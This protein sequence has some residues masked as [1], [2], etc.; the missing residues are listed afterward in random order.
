MTIALAL[1]LAQ[2][3]AAPEGPDCAKAVVQQEM[4]YCAAQE[5]HAADAE[6][7]AQWRITAAQMR[8]R[9]QETAVRD[10]QREDWPGYFETLLAGQRAWLAYRDAQCD[11]EGFEARGGSMEPMLVA[12]CRTALTRQR[13]RQLQDLS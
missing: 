3:G 12:L 5:F 9:D 4:N 6:M 13:T 1:L 10:D 11:S 7:N 2:A 8:R